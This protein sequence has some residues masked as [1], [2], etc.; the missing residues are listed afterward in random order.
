MLFF[1]K[2]SWQVSI[3]CIWFVPVDFPIWDKYGRKNFILKCCNQL[4]SSQANFELIMKYHNMHRETQANMTSPTTTIQ[5]CVLVL[6]LEI[7]NTLP[8]QSQL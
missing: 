6:L 1:F 3:I 8:G 7:L 2:N 5:N 4:S